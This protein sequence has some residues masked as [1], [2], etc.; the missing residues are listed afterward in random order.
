V[1][2]DWHDDGQPEPTPPGR[3]PGR[4]I[5]YAMVAFGVL[6]LGFVLMLAV[7]LDPAADRFHNQQPPADTKP[8]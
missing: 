7:R 1:T 2:T 4:Y 3:T 6:L 5:V 8:R